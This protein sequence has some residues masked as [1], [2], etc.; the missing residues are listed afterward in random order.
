[1]GLLSELRRRNVLRMAALY[2]VAAWLIMQVVEVVSGLAP[3]PD[4]I[5]PAT[6]GVLAVGFP[7][8]LVLSWIYELTPE[9]ISLE[10][11]VRPGESITHLTGRRLDFIV[12]ALLSAALLVFAWDKWGTPAPSEQSIAVLPFDA[13]GAQENGA[14]VLAAGI[15]D[16][17]LTRL[18]QI[19]SFRV[20]S[21]TSVERYANNSISVGEIAAELGVRR[22]VEGGVQQIG[23]QIRVNVQLIDADTDEHIWAETYDRSLTV[24]DIFPIQSEIVE[25]IAHALDTTLTAEESEQLASMPTLSFDAYTEY[26]RGKH[27]A[28]EETIE[29]LYD[30]IDHFNAAIDLDPEF[31]LAYVGLADAYLTLNENFLGGLPADEAVALAEPPLTR[32]LM[33]DADSSEAQACLG[34]LR[35]VQG[36]FDA[37]VQAYE[38]SIAIRPSYSR[39]YR[40]YGRLR[41]REGRPDEA[42]S[43]MQKALRLDPYSA[44]INLMVGRLH[45][46]AGQFD[47]AMT[48]FLKVIEIEPDHAFAYVYVAAIHYLVH[49]RIDESIVWY[50]R[51]AE[52]DAMSP[53]LQ[54][55]QALAYIEIGD[56]DNAKI[57]VD[58]AAEIG[59]D[60][61][62]ALWSNV[63]LSKFIGDPEAT[64]AAARAM[65]EHYP[66]NWGSLRFLRDADIAAG[67]SEVAR[68]RYARAYRELTEPEI[69]DVNVTNYPVAVDLALVL[70][71]TGETDRA[72][73]LLDGSLEVMESLSRLGVNG[74]WLNDVRAL[75]LK[76]QPELAL[77]RLREA[78][79][80]GWRFQVWYHMDLDPNLDSIRSTEEFI[81]LNA[82]LRADL[83][84]Q[85]QHV[86][87][88]KASGELAMMRPSTYQ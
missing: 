79:D 60:T 25:S 23:D 53:S 17:L 88:M 45:D 12:I 70:Q 11:D 44:P 29:S 72:E 83:E 69:P 8:A 21:R 67:R 1:M 33:L 87:D 13:V 30:A 78:I 65:L 57:W 2:I 34:L 48:H 85:A 43:L 41:W 66:R 59:P 77:E 50:G 52:N 74:Y 55:A 35:Q 37:A 24:S 75:T 82:R 5:G 15:Q 3:L 62:W 47:D 14:D 54:A 63:A 81:E 51:A 22:I 26:L 76:Q 38:K 31:A 64:Q 61:F 58:R 46:E 4:W 86:R 49:G 73:D 27:S 84:A 32:A 71:L 18:S 7:I 20:I 16:G 28:D 80:D 9:G 56:P 19:D 40:F 39:A 36:N 42:M 6:L 10:K 68:A